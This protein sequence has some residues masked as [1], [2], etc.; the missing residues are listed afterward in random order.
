MCICE[1]IVN[2]ADVAVVD[3]SGSLLEV[4]LMSDRVVSSFLAAHQHMLVLSLSYMKWEM[5]NSWPERL[6]YNG[7]YCYSKI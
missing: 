2:A 7:G 6:K 4:E 1:K 5:L 3:I